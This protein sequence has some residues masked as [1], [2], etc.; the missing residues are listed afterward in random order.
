MVGRLLVVRGEFG[1]GNV[2]T[3]SKWEEADTDSSGFLKGVLSEAGLGWR[4]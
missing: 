3:S 4:V 2:L 1:E